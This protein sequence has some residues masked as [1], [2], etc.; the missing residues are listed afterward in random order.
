MKTISA[1]LI[2]YN[3][4]AKIGR[5]LETLA[6]VADEI[7][8][9]DSGSTDDTLGICR[10]RGLV[11]I[12]RPWTGYREQKTFATRQ[13]RHPWVL[14]LDCDEWLSAGLQREILEWKSAPDENLS[15]YLMPRLTWFLD[16]WIRHTTW[17]PDWQLRLFRPDQGSWQGGRVHESFRTQGSVGRFSAPL[18]HHTYSDLSEYL[19]QLDSF[20]SLA[21]RE[22]HAR[23]ERPGPLKVLASPPAAFFKN[24][25]LKRGFLDGMPG[26]A[27]SAMAA[28]SALFKQLKLLEL[29]R[30]SPP[31]EDLSDR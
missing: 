28:V 30:N 20:S 12:S 26:L 23:G 21:A 8:V 2:S 10:Q 13:A 16:R 15:G 25:L 3:E 27:V 18:L 19:R 6:H 14:S 7:V 9:V 29:A 31:K 1:V 5:A 17:H 4:E 22:L 24:Y 11:P